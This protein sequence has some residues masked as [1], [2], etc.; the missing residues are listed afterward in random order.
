M[1]QPHPSTD[2]LVIPSEYKYVVASLLPIAFL[3]L[4]Q[5][6]LVGRYRKSA[7]IPYPQPYAEKAEAQASREAHL[8]NCAQRAHTNTLELLPVILI[9]VLTSGLVFPK[10]AATTSL[11]FFFSRIFYTRGYVTGDPSKRSGGPLYLMSTLSTLGLL[12]VT[13]YVAGQWV[14]FGA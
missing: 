8:F 7:G 4:G 3:L 10:L 5:S 12:L 13:T 6:I 2:G 1:I 11:I 9:T 14:V